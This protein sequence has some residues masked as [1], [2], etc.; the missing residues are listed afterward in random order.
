MKLLK[1]LFLT[2]VRG[3]VLKGSELLPVVMR[4]LLDPGLITMLNVNKILL[5]S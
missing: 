4:D 5:R 2:D 3:G 1:K